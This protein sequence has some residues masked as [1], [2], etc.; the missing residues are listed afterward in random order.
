MVECKPE[1]WFLGFNEKGTFIDRVTRSEDTIPQNQL[2]QGRAAGWQRQNDK[3]WHVLYPELM[4]TSFTSGNKVTPFVDGDAYVTSLR[5]D[6]GGLRGGTNFVL[7]AGW[8]FTKNFD[9]DRGGQPGS[10]LTEVIKG[11][12]QRGVETRALAFDNPIPGI[13]NNL[14]VDAVNEVYPSVSQ[15][16]L[17]SAYL[18]PARGGAAFSHHQK[19]VFIGF[20]YFTQCCAYV[21]GIDLAMDRW[22]TPEHRKPVKDNHFFGWHDVQV[23]VE[24]N[25][26]HALWANFAERWDSA[27][28]QLGMYFSP[29]YR[30]RP[31]R[32]QPCPVPGYTDNTPGPG[33]H[34]VQVLRTVAEAPSSDRERFMPNGELTVLAG[35][36]KAIRNAECY[37]YIE[38]QFLWDCELADLIR[39]Q[40]QKKPGLRLIVVLAAETE[41]KPRL[42]KEYSYYLRSQFLM[43]V[44]GV[45]STEEIAFGRKTRV[46]VYGLYQALRKSPKAIYVH[47]KLIIIDDRYVA[48]GSANVDKRSMRIETELTLGIVDDATVPSTLGGTPATV[49]RFAKDLREQLWKEHLN[50]PGPLPDDPIQALQRF[51]EGSTTPWQDGDAYTWPGPAN[52]GRAKQLQSYHARCYVNVAGDDKIPTSLKRTLDRGERRWRSS[53]EA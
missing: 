22:D 44:M 50:V 53:G 46:Y 38:E 12:A 40:L 31:Y 52:R 47:S 23:K 30:L 39:D 17:R 18:E 37:I 36:S 8:E 49:C 25:V 21:G 14:F 27:D 33:T 13:K 32:L 51:P 16:P 42:G 5:Q 4:I 19:E 11:L 45:N 29:S 43:R 26:L 6:L 20:K 15:A 10:Q 35:L 7:M 34:H 9:L 28:R 48:I 41:L 2:L 3:R 24:G 1:D